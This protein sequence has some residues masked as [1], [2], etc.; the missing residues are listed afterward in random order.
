MSGVAATKA[1]LNIQM[2]VGRR[3]EGSADKRAVE[4]PGRFEVTSALT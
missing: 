1:R 3:R 4:A 2:V